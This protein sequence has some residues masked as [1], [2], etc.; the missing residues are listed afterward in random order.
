MT[1]LNLLTAS[2]LSQAE[3]AKLCGVSLRT[4]HRWCAGQT[5][6]KSVVI[7][8]LTAYAKR[9]ARAREE[10]QESLGNS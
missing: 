4:M 9:M 7:E 8:A 1:L 6:P 5:A 3:A 2:N 10:L